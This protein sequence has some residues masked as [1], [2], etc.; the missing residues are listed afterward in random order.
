MFLVDY[1]IQGKLAPNHSASSRKSLLAYLHTANFILKYHEVFLNQYTNL[2][3]I[4]LDTTPSMIQ[5]GE[6][7]SKFEQICSHG[8]CIQ[9]T[10]T[11][12]KNRRNKFSTAEM[13]VAL[14]LTISN[15]PPNQHILT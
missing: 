2:K 9:T 13:E 3:K 15:K 11:K 8:G 1:L 4:V 7:I 12:A 5:K 10:M 6:L 14:R